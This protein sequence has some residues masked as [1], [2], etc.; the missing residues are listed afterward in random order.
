[1]RV[2]CGHNIFFRLNGFGLWQT[3]GVCVCVCVRYGCHWQHG[4]LVWCTCSSCH[5]FSCVFLAF[6]FHSFFRVLDGLKSTTANNL[7]LSCAHTT[8]F[9]SFANGVFSIVFKFFLCFCFSKITVIIKLIKNTHL[10][11]VCVCHTFK[12]VNGLKREMKT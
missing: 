2:K 3:I 11:C 12:W 4:C 9:L 6:F 10:L 7:S 5:S 1:M 8:L